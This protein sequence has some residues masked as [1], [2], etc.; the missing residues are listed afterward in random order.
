MLTKFYLILWIGFTPLDSGERLPSSYKVIDFYDAYSCQ[1][2]LRQLRAEIPDYY[3]D[4]VCVPYY[5][6]TEIKTND[7][8]G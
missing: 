2:S 1:Q 5:H 7:P 3:V 8:R 4:G 6:S